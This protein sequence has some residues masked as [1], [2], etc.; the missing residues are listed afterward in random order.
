MYL[1]LCDIEKKIIIYQNIRWSNS[2]L[3]IATEQSSL[4]IFFWLVYLSNSPILSAVF[5]KGYKNFI[6]QFCL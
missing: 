2:K 3:Q 6:E 1:Q 4:K 5:K